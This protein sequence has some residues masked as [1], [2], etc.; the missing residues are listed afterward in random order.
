MLAIDPKQAW[1]LTNYPKMIIPNRCMRRF[2]DDA[3]GPLALIEMRNAFNAMEEEALGGL[4]DIAI[5]C[6]DVDATYCRLQPSHILQV[7]CVR[8]QRQEAIPGCL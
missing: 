1:P 4:K 5:I 2:F 7:L 8:R 3:Q 6:K